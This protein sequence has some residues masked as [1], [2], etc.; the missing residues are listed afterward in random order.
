VWSGS[1]I[2]FTRVLGWWDWGFVRDTQG[3]CSLYYIV[4]HGFA[5]E[6]RVNNPS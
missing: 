3:S 6:A 1:W 5:G 2:C 4:M